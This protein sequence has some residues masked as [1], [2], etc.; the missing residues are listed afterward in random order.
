MSHLAD[1]L[2]R[3]GDLEFDQLE[4]V[5]G[6]QAYRGGRLEHLLVENRMIPEKTLVAAIARVTGT[7][8]ARLDALRPDGTALA[9][10][11]DAFCWE[12]PCFPVSYDEGNRSLTVA[13]TDPT[14]IALIDE[15]IQ[16]SGCRVKALVGGVAE[17][18]RAIRRHYRGEYVPDDEGEGLTL[19][20]GGEEEFKITDMSGKTVMTSL[21][22]LKAQHEA[23]QA[24]ATP[25]PS[26]PPAAPRGSGISGLFSIRVLSPDERERLERVRTNLEKSQL[27]L[28][29][30]LSLLEE[31]GVLRQAEVHG[32]AGR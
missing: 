7:P 19:D 26:P 17:I 16:R 21:Q 9:R 27:I 22:A 23:Q 18:R 12:L 30:I 24:Q 6:Q 4:S 13:V 3:S 10:L 25:A 20:E 14:D 1:L 32:R 28:S 15:I 8:V 5:R 31:K 29:A 2:L 11:P